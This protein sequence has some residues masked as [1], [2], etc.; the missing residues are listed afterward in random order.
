MDQTMVNLRGFPEN[1]SAWSL[2]WY[3]NDPCF[4]FSLKIYTEQ[5]LWKFGHEDLAVHF[6]VGW[7][8]SSRTC[9]LGG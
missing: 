3:C 1:N 4:I 6:M 7:L 8:V 2:G 5:A 9:K